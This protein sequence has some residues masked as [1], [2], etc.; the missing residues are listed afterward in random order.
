[1]S[2]CIIYHKITKNTTTLPQETMLSIK[3]SHTQKLIREVKFC[4]DTK[5]GPLPANSWLVSEVISGGGAIC[6]PRSST[7]PALLALWR[8]T[9]RTGGLGRSGIGGWLIAANRR[10]HPPHSTIARGQRISLSIA[11]QWAGCPAANN[12]ER[13]WSELATSKT[14][15]NS[16]SF[17]NDIISRHGSVAKTG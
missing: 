8:Q 13:S 6:R 10:S 14:G 11:E 17:L 1:M 15:V 4:D 9:W 2:L 16:P 7:Q 12:I 5:S 3:I